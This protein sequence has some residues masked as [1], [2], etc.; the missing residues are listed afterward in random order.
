MVRSILVRF[1]S[2]FNN[3]D[4]NP[5]NHTHTATEITLK[6]GH[7]DILREVRIS[8][9]TCPDQLSLDDTDQFQIDTM[10]P[11]QIVKIPL[12]FR[13]RQDSCNKEASPDSLNVSIV[14]TFKRRRR[15]RSVLH[16]IRLPFYTSAT[17]TSPSKDAKYKLTLSLKGDEDTPDLS[18]IFQEMFQQ[19]DAGEAVSI[20]RRIE[21]NVVA[22]RFDSSK[23]E[24]ESTTTSQSR[25]TMLGSKSK[26]RI[27]LQSDRLDALY[28]V[29][30]EFVHRL[31]R[32]V[33]YVFFFMFLYFFEQKQSIRTYTHT[34]RYEDTL[35]LL[36]L[37]TKIDEHFQARL[38]VEAAKHSLDKR[39]KQFRVVQKRLLVRYKDRNSA[40]LNGLDVLMRGTYEQIVQETENVELKQSRLRVAAR[41]LRV[42]LR[43]LL[44]LMKL[45]FKLDSKSFEILVSSFCVN[46]LCEYETEEQGWEEVV[47]ASLVHL[48]RTVLSSCSSSSS[49]SSIG[50]TSS[51]TH[52]E[53]PS[54][55]KRLKNRI[56]VV[57][58]RL[59]KGSSLLNNNVN[60]KYKK[61]ELSKS[62]SIAVA[63][64]IS[65]GDRVQGKMK[66]KVRMSMVGRHH[67]S[68][69]SSSSG[70]KTKKKVRI[71]LK[72]RKKVIDDSEDVVSS[73]DNSSSK[74]LD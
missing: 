57:A 51:L 52:L 34:H 54:N 32:E 36:D 69:E 64:K 25:C 67:S 62:S 23:N 2:S 61:K 22:F 29:A 45:K 55:T 60:K 27:R 48:L 14:V 42:T 40:P 58:D 59:S 11:D 20:L 15:V 4:N 50:M 17:L 33:T 39:A 74:V 9:M 12:R 16:T 7:V 21:A 5:P 19:K 47:D 26:R 3:H 41:R 43:L 24:D 53:M 8:V 68:I 1:F 28:L 35:P 46:H 56:A 6:N 38:S 31:R 72:R 44:F 18:Q 30:D 71:K 10:G 49:S 65:D 70:N 37:F 13:R 66:S 63:S 73:N